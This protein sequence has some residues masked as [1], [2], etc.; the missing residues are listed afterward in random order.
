MVIQKMGIQVEV[1]YNTCIT[2]EC[3]DGENTMSVKI[4][5][6]LLRVINVWSS[7]AILLE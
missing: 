1:L 3:E 2:M 6:L 4:C 5:G 7:A